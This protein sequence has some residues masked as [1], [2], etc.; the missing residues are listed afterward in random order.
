[1]TSI[2]VHIGQRIAARRIQ[3]GMDQDELSRLAGVSRENVLRYEL[4]SVRVSPVILV[5][6]CEVLGMS[7]ASVFVGFERES[8]QVYFNEPCSVI[9]LW[10]RRPRPKRH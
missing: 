5:R 4:G 8:V 9:D 2:D 10:S 1:V 7:V 6:V 3:L